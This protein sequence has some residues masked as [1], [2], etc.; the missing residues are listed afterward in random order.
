MLYETEEKYLKQAL[1]IICVSLVAS[2][3][4]LLSPTR[5]KKLV[6]HISIGICYLNI[7]KMFYFSK[8]GTL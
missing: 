2:K 6:D 3:L 5:K 8:V 1:K 7:T 4:S